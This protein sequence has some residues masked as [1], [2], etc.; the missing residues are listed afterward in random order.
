N[1]SEVTEA[2]YQEF[3]EQISGDRGKPAKI[4]HFSVEGKTEFRALLF[5]PA[6]RPMAFDYQEPKAGLKLYVQRVLIM[7]ECEAILPTYLRFVKGVVDCP[8]LPLNVSRELLQ[9]NPHLETIQKNV[10]RNILSGLDGLRN[11]QPEAFQQFYNGL[12]AILKEG[13]SRDW[14]NRDK[15]ADLLQFETSLT[16]AGEF[17][18]LPEYVARM[19]ADQEAIYY[20]IGESAAQLRN[21]PYL[22]RPRARGH[23]V[24]LMTDPIDEFVFPSYGE[25]QKKKFQAVDRGELKTDDDTILP[26][27]R[28]L[29]AKLIE[30]LKTLLPEVAEVRLSRRLTT[31][32][33]CLVADGSA[34]SAQMER[35][36][37]KFGDTVT[38]QKRVL[39]L[40]P[41]HELLLNLEQSYRKNPDDPRLSLTARLLLD[42]AMIAEGSK[43]PDPSGFAERLNELLLTQLRD[44]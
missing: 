40:N 14:S 16:A 31:S 18:T 1:K 17:R 21:S 4:L 2:E 5:I 35:L 7:D 19:P 24:L 26:E 29:F 20:Y 3:Y 9:R 41:S 28:E 23:E 36:M 43:I 6:E 38:G 13:L 10:V 37:K 39:E 8:D 15:I 30:K 22:E 27:T 32:A 33:A 25:Y 44:K 12:G 11:T 42:Q 34:M